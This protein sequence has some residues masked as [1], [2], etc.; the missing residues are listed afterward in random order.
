MPRRGRPELPDSQL[1][2]VR[3]VRISDVEW[4]DIKAEAAAAGESVSDYVRLAALARV[5]R[6]RRRRS[7]EGQSS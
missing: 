5:K 1:R 3:G 4:E 7:T 2:K 6:D